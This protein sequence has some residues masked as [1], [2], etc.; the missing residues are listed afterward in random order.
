MAAST[1]RSQR[2]ISFRH[3]ARIEA[4][5]AE[6]EPLASL[7]H[8]DIPKL[9]RASR[10]TIEIGSFKTDCCTQFVRAIVRRGM[11]T[12]LVVE[13]C[14]D[15]KVKPPNAELVRLID[16]ARK[17]LARPGAKPLRDPIPVAEFM[18]NAMAITVD[19]ITCVR[20]CFLGICFVCCTTINTDQYYCGDR[21]IIHRD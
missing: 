9:S 12:E 10:A 5:R 11:V 4:S 17:R 20:I 21:V 1:R 6:F 3:P 19:T 8:L 13:P 15:D 2:S 18:K 14:S 16:I 7:T